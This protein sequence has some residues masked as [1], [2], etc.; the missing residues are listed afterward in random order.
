M[1]AIFI[2]NDFYR[3]SNTIM[4]SV[5]EIKNGVLKRTDW[6]LIQTALEKGQ[7]VNVRPAN[8]DEMFWAYKKLAE[9]N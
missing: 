2:G 4:S 6:G 9:I 7:T 8:N 1:N 5:Y 3:K